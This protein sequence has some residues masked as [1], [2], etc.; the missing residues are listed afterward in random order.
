MAAEKPL[1]IL[2]AREFQNSIGDSVHKLLSDQIDDLGLTQAYTIEKAYIRSACGSEFLF[3]GLRN[4]VTKIKSFE[5]IDIVWVEEAQ[6]VSKASWDVL[7]PTIRKEGSEI[8]VTFNPALETDETYQRFV[9]NP[10]RNAIV[11][12]IDWRD[13]PWFPSVLREEMEA[14][15][16]RDEDAWL[17]VWEGHCRRTLEGAI[18]AKE[19]R[20]LEV[21]G[22]IT[23]V[24]Y[25]PSKPVHTFWD[26]GFADCTAIWLAQSVGLETRIIGYIEAAQQPLTYYVQELQKLPYVWGTDWLPHDARARQL[27]TGRSIEE[28]LRG[29]GRTVRITPQLSVVDGINAA[30]TLMQTCWIDAARCADGLQ[31]LRNYRYDVDP[32][33]GQFSQKPLHDDASHGADAFRYLAVAMREPRAGQVKGPK[34]ISAPMSA[35]AGGW[36]AV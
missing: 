14:L 21:S 13:N 33:T 29:M 34:I 26:L 7:I 31:R 23:S 4:N 32:V 22:R 20:G 28:M 9:A 35:A 10:P 16:E 8:W 24:P 15:R 5:G 2:C 27:G 6:T 17:N 3:A 11:E 1:R 36:G 18:Y 25:D 30:R 12:K 19:L